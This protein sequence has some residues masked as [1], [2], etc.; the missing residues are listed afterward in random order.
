[1]AE[2]QIGGVEYRTARL[3]ARQQWNVVRRLAPLLAAAGDLLKLAAPA[4]EGDDAPKD[5]AFAA[6][7][8]FAE[9]LAGLTDDASDYIL[10][11]CMRATA[12]RSGDQWR[13]I[14]N[15]GVMMFDDIDM[16]AM[17][18]IAWNVMQESLSGFLGD[19]PGLSRS[20]AGPAQAG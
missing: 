5:D 3:N 4:T 20:Q 18:Q 13:P 2:F 17:L 11:T 9:A 8:P 7:A 12:R 19:L 14:F 10:D 6:F 15:G 1:M 16:K